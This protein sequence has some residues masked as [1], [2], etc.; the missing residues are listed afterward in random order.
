MKEVICRGQ[1]KNG[2]WVVGYYFASADRKIKYIVNYSNTE[3][4]VPVF[5]TI[6]PNTLGMFSGSFDELG[7]RIFEHDLLN[8]GGTVF[9]VVFEKGAFVTR[10]MNDGKLYDGVLLSSWEA[11]VM[12]RVGN[13][14]DGFTEE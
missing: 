8:I 13:I 10:R 6:K 5:N 1:I 12:R 14:F 11:H 9:R 7:D 2:G 4:A 3:K